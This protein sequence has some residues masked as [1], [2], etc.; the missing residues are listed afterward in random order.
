MNCDCPS[1]KKASKDHEHLFRK[2][3]DYGWTLVWLELSKESSHHQ[4]HHYGIPIEYCPFC[5][6]KLN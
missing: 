4:V 3:P 1:W 5:G 6:K 2:L